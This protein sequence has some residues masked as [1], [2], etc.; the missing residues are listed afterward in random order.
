[1]KKIILLILIGVFLIG[2]VGATQQSLG[3]FKQ[4]ECV[5]LVQTCGNCTHN[6]LSRVLKTGDSAGISIINLTMTKDGTFY[7]YS[8][9]DT[10][11]LGIY[12]V[13]GV[14]DPNGVITI[15]NYN[16]EV[17]GTGVEDKSIW[18]NPLLLI[19]LVLFAMLF[20]I[21]YQTK[22]AWLGFLSSIPVFVR[23]RG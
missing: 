16:F 1:M 18:N 15:W 2:L 20:T 17:T 6:N 5:E 11:T 14:G 23:M 21:A 13:H 9:C 8:F 4:Y 3:V 7:N 22:I 19:S 12:I 10:T